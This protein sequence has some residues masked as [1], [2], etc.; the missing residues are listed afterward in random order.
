MK[1]RK[2]SLLVVNEMPVT[3]INK[4]RHEHRAV[5]SSNG[6]DVRTVPINKSD[7]G[8]DPLTKSASEQL[9]KAKISSGR[10]NSVIR[11]MQKAKAVKSYHK[12]LN[13]EVRPQPTLKGIGLNGLQG[14]AIE[15]RGSISDTPLNEKA[16]KERR[17]GEPEGTSGNQPKGGTLPIW[18]K[19]KHTMGCGE[20]KDRAECSKAHIA[21]EEFDGLDTRLATLLRKKKGACR[22]SGQQNTMPAGSHKKKKGVPILM[23]RF[24]YSHLT[25]RKIN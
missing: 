14:R 7:D 24:R 1:G 10:Q 15:K 5:N 19:G 8:S 21:Q 22:D 23:G 11:G 18:A 6:A 20:L 2:T 12:F 13:K 9:D 17:A 4:K 3:T 16:A 25:G